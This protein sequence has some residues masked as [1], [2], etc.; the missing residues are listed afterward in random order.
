MELYDVT[1]IPSFHTSLVQ[2]RYGRTFNKIQITYC[3]T[4][5][6]TAKRNSRHLRCDTLCRAMMAIAA[7]FGLEAYQWDIKNAFVNATMDEEVFVECPDGFKQQNK[8]HASTKST[9]WPATITEIM[10]R[11]IHHDTNRPWT[12][13]RNGRFMSNENVIPSFC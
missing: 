3:R 4:R 11:N 10:T 9:I 7:Y 2:I 5:R 12:T 1:Y 6:P 8:S 13:T